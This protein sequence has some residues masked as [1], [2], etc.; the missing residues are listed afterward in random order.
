MLAGLHVIWPLGTA[1]QATY[2]P[3]TVGAAAVAAVAARRLVGVSGRPWRWVAAGLVCSALGD[4]YWAARDATGTTVPD[5]SLADPAW[6]GAYVFLIAAMFALLRHRG[7]GNRTD[8]EGLIDTGVA[9]VVSL[10][11]FWPT[12]VAPLL[13]DPATALTTRLV[14]T[15]YPVLDA[16][17]LALVL[18][19][20][21]SRRAGTHIG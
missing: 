3:F 18:R 1:G 21:L 19:A 10:L 8:L 14:W 15:L 2:L 16:A 12:V 5:V 17:L 20:V 9:L 4:L 7:D 13:D 6:I 11:V